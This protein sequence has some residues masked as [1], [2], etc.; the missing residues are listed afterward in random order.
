MHS[1]QSLISGTDFHM[2]SCLC[3][4][5][6]VLQCICGVPRPA[7][8]YSHFLKTFISSSNGASDTHFLHLG[9]AESLSGR[10]KR[11]QFVVGED[12]FT[13]S[14][15]WR[16]HFPPSG[17]HRISWEHNWRHK[18]H[19][20]AVTQGSS[21]KTLM[22]G[23]VLW[24]EK[25]KNPWS[26][27]HI[28]HTLWNSMAGIYVKQKHFVL[29]THYMLVKKIM[30][31]SKTFCIDW[32]RQSYVCDVQYRKKCIISCHIVWQHLWF[33][34]DQSVVIS[35]RFWAAS[36]DWLQ[37]AP[38]WQFPAVWKWWVWWWRWWWRNG[39]AKSEVT[40]ALICHFH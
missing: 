32:P 39:K 38:N 21:E 16:F 2:I 28:A 5:N 8:K 36:K 4:A 31:L 9:W 30:R 17:L 23:R 22:W 18:K 27:L 3:T 1:V 12:R 15:W 7:G 26:D 37:F 29:I 11:A 25:F 19:F 24:V 20:P 33:P 40:V 13:T 6:S 10:F 34:D 14:S 35:G